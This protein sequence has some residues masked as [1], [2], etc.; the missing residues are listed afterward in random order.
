[1]AGRSLAA[2]G[3]TISRLAI[4]AGGAHQTGD[5]NIYI[6]NPGV[7]DETGNVRIGRQ[8]GQTATFIAGIA[9]A[10]VPTGVAVIVDVNGHLGTTTSSARYKEAVKPM[11]KAS[12]AILSLKPVTFRY[13]QEL[14]PHGIAQFG[15][16]AEEVGKV[17]PVLVARDGDGKALQRALRR[18][19][20]SLN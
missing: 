17:N 19:A 9:G 5:H 4:R 2:P 20:Q 12:E 1:M 3:T 18:G 15:L 13:K 10:T 11:D 8:G 16:V 6:G 14:D 7:A